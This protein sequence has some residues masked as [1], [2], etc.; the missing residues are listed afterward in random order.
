MTRIIR[1]G[2]RASKLSLWQARFAADLIREHYDVRV[3]LKPFQ[4]RGD[5][6]RSRPLTAIGGKGLF[7]QELEAALR[8]QEIDCAVHSLK[9]LPTE[10][11]EGL[12][13]GAVPQRGNPHDV[14]V[15]REGKSLSSLPMGARIGTGSR[16]RRAQLLY[17]RPDLHILNIRGNVPTRMQKLMAAGGGYDAIVLAAA[18]LERLEMSDR[19]SDT[20]A[21]PRMV[22]AAGQG[23][24]AIQCRAEPEATD[25][26][27][28]LTD[29]ATQLAVTAERAFL[30]ALGGGCSL[31]VG[32]YAFV[33]GH[34]LH[35]RGRVT[36]VDGGRQVDVAGE[37]ARV[38]DGKSIQSA[39]QLGV[40][41]ARRALQQGA[42][43]ILPAL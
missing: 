24:L 27:A 4:T 39:R 2:S 43:E 40:D 41:L 5:R 38:S 34:R 13:L 15:S 32:A 20:F 17:H 8:R 16:R 7:T 19:I 36:A 14:L 29:E 23:A 22:S 30:A 31:P 26:F 9:D 21:I 3:E 6:I 18:G 11:A 42:A 28:P 35:L 25:F 10:E 33:E 12:C 1:I 37:T